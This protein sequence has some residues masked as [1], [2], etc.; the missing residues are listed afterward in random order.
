[1]RGSAFW[2]RTATAHINSNA[3]ATTDRIGLSIRPGAIRT[4]DGWCK[5]DRTDPSHR[6]RRRT[7]GQKH[8]DARRDAAVVSRR[9]RLGHE[10]RGDA[11]TH[12]ELHAAPGLQVMRVAQLNLAHRE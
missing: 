4:V 2:A 1:M 12:P 5:G 11:S 3:T 10:T 8:R 9:Q 6:V 7:H